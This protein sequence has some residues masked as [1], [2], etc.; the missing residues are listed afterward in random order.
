MTIQKTREQ[1][2]SFRTLHLLHACKECYRYYHSDAATAME[3]Q[4][5]DLHTFF[6]LCFVRLV[7]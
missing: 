3:R 1:S 2:K 5:S 7:D 6:L 4:Q